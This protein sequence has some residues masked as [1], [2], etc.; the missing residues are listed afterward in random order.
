MSKI[1]LEPPLLQSKKPRPPTKE[2]L[3]PLTR[4][5]SGGGDQGGKQENPATGGGTIEAEG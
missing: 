2:E 4:R 1:S 3:H 5:N